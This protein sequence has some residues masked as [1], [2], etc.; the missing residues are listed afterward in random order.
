MRF[1]L[2]SVSM[3]S[4]IVFAMLFLA[5]YTA[6]V[7]QQE[8]AYEIAARDY[9]RILADCGDDLVCSPPA[10]AAAACRHSNNVIEV[11]ADLG[12]RRRFPFGASPVKASLYFDADDASVDVS[13]FPSCGP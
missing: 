11:S 8:L 7:N 4:I 10:V 5:D 9:R 12:H 1:A 13:A 2:M 6:W 3:V